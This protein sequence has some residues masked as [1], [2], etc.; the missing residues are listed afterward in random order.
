MAE[1]GSFTK[2]PDSR[3]GNSERLEPNAPGQG[4]AGGGEPVKRC[5][6]KGNGGQIMKDL[7]EIVFLL[8]SK[9]PFIIFKQGSDMNKLKQ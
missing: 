5:S 4:L 9:K 6:W 3:V 1:P 8:R 7:E 2:Q